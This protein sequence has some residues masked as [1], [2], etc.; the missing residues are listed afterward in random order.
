M[1]GFLGEHILWTLKSSSELSSSSWHRGAPQPG[2]PGRVRFLHQG[3]TEPLPCPRPAG[4]LPAERI[5]RPPHAF[6]R[7]K[8]PGAA[9]VLPDPGGAA[10][11]PGEQQEDVGP[12]SH[13]V[14]V[15]ASVWPT[16][17]VSLWRTHNMHVVET[18]PKY[19]FSWDIMYI[20][21]ITVPLKVQ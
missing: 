9:A 7:W 21:T 2:R 4:R 5:H 15:M 14:S 10:V 8:C 11:Q 12:V 18:L 17:G 3:R 16:A 1:L 19:K 13:T 20:K 6:S